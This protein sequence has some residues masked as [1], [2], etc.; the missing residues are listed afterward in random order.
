MADIEKNININVT[1]NADQAASSVDKLGKALDTAS[2]SSAEFGQAAL[3]NGGVMGVLNELTGG[4]AGTVKDAIEAIQFLTAKKKLDT[5]STAANVAATE[6]STVATVSDNTARQLA[7][8]NKGKELVSTVAVKT[9]QLAAAAATKVVTAAQWLW[10]AAIAANP[11]VALVVAVAAAGVA[12]Y[13]LTSFLMSNSEANDK[14][15]AAAKAAEKQIAAQGRAAENSSENLKTHNDHLY[16]MAKAAGAT[17][18]QLRKLKLK[19]AEEAIEL[20]KKN[21]IIAKN[22]YEVEK[23]ALAYLRYNDASDEAIKAQEAVVVK[24]REALLKQNENLTASYKQRTAVINTNEEEAL[25]EVTD[26]ENKK[27]EARKKA[28]DDAKAK[29][30]KAAEEARKAAEDNKNKL[31]DIEKRFQQEKLDVEADTD[32]KKLD[33]EKKRAIAELDAIKMNESEKTAARLALEADFAAKQK[34]LDDKIAADKK[35]KDD[36]LKLKNAEDLKALLDSRLLT[37]QE[38]AAVETAAEVE[39]LRVKNEAVL[40]QQ[41]ADD[42]AKAEKFGATEAEIAAIKAFY[43]Q[44]KTTNDAEAAEATKQIDE[45]TVEAKKAMLGGISATLNTAADLLG[46]NTTAGKAMAIAATTIDTFQS[47][48]AAYKGMVAAIPGP[49]GV[50]AGAV[51]AAGAIATGLATVKKIVSVKV[52]G[53][54]GGGATGGGIAAV[55]AATAPSMS[56]VGSS[57]NQ[58]GSTIAA[59]TNEQP[60]V[61]AYVVS[62]DMS[63]A[64]QLDRNL[65][66]ATTVG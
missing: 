11:L 9:A 20:A 51:A 12:I 7:I 21:Q 5:A 36:E 18:E 33:L 44:E 66:S 32:Q 45:K 61:K 8:I 17:S 30:E 4:F 28:D 56:F 50:I 47:S 59:N 2:T 46:K 43:N 40:I 24:A 58:I 22:T 23:N 34:A 53:G 65:I 31:I 10:N 29:R 6:A 60:P 16:N 35:A 57:A 49:G 25:K 63:T 19:H 15:M 41:E 54:G 42:I 64:Q 55:P 52:P 48:M 13:K 62:Q 3:D 1:T 26:A 14:A 37:Q 39:A 38:Y 27:K